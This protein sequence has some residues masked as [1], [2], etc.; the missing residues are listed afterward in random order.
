[1]RPTYSDSRGSYSQRAYTNTDTAEHGVSRRRRSFCCGEDNS[2]TRIQEAA[3]AAQVSTQASGG[4]REQMRNARSLSHSALAASSCTLFAPLPDYAKYQERKTQRVLSRRC[5]FSETPSSPGLESRQA[6]LVICTDLLDVA[7][8]QPASPTSKPRQNTSRSKQTTAIGSHLCD[9]GE[10]ARTETI[11]DIKKLK[12]PP[13]VEDVSASAGAQE[14]QQKRARNQLPSGNPTD[15][16]R[17]E[18]SPGVTTVLRKADETVRAIH[19]SFFVPVTCSCGKNDLFC[20]A[21]AKYVLCPACRVVSPVEERPRLCSKGLGMGFSY[22]T[23]Q[24][25]MMAAS[26]RRC[27]NWRQFQGTVKSVQDHVL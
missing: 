15:V 19:N 8:R 20:I 5:V 1:M 17:I 3:E 6:K 25:E 22:D 10:A 4:R 23:I 11:A 26:A 12:S 27:S 9:Q 21:D 14:D 13:L 16:T 24:A 7:D 2:A 18:V